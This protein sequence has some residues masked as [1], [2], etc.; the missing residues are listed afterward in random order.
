MAKPTEIEFSIS[1]DN[2]FK[3]I[4]TLKDL[5]KLDDQV[6][7]KFDNKNTLIYSLVGEGQN[8]NA[9]KSFIFKTNEIFDI[10][11]ELTVQA[12]WAKNNIIHTWLRFANQHGDKSGA[13][14]TGIDYT[15]RAVTYHTPNHITPKE[16]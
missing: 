12:D 9:F 16:E 4:Q 7:F 8:V 13:E 15:V 5:S 3:L 10:E 14:L 11:T 1:K 6:L 2:L